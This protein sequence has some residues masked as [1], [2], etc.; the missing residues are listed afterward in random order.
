MA[1][2]IVRTACLLAVFFCMDRMAVAQASVGSVAIQ[3]VER[4]TQIATVAMAGSGSVTIQGWEQSTSSSGGLR[5]FCE[6]DGVCPSNGPIF[7]SGTIALIVN[8]YMASANYGSGSTSESIASALAMGFNYNPASPVTAT[9]SGSTITL[10][11]RVLG[12]ST[13]YALSAS[14]SF[15]DADFSFPSFTAD[16]AELLTG[17]QDAGTL[18]VYDTGTVSANISS[19][20]Q[21]VTYGQGDT[22]ISVATRLAEAFNADC[23]S[24]F[25]ASAWSDDSGAYVDFQFKQGGSGAGYILGLSSASNSAYFSGTAF[26]V[27]VRPLPPTKYFSVTLPARA[28]VGGTC[29]GRNAWQSLSADQQSTK[30]QEMQ[31]LIAANAQQARQDMQDTQAQFGWEG[32]SPDSP[33]AHNLVNVNSASVFAP[34]SFVDQSGAPVANPV[35]MTSSAFQIISGALASPTGRWSNFSFISF[36]NHCAHLPESRG[37]FSHTLFP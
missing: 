13:N 35:D 6:I 28:T 12:A 1:K 19:H 15:D 4:A 17:G 29:D 34:I 8:G 27:N 30:L 20:P 32:G 26:P 33:V 22:A 10:R 16:T 7:D 11:A 23:N 36:E 2:Q 25:A 18:T 3:G 5:E 37:L 24:L 31:N 9:V 21:T 14:Y